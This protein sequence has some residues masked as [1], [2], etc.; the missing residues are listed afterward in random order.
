MDGMWGDSNRV[1]GLELPKLLISLLNN[2]LWVHP[3]DDILG[4][5]IPWCRDPFVFLDR[6][7]MIQ[8]SK[9]CSSIDLFFRSASS[10]ESKQRVPPLPWI[11]TDLAVMIGCNKHLGDDVGICLDYRTDSLDPCVVAS[12]WPEKSSFDDYDKFGHFWR[13]VTPTFSEFAKILNLQ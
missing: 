5:V 2:N 1:N 6:E 11:D 8:E 9:Q 4:R 3:G 12:Y 13:E 10:K 7:M